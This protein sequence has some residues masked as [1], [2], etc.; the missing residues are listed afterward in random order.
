MD[1][2]AVAGLPMDESAVVGHSSHSLD[3]LAAPVDVKPPMMPRAK[4]R[5]VSSSA[6]T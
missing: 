3:S 1:E 6:A 5:H 2:S 4:N